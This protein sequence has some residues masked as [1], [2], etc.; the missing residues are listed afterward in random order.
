M[1]RAGLK[2]MIFSI[3]VTPLIQLPK[4]KSLKRMMIA[5][6]T[7][8]CS[9]RKKD[10]NGHFLLHRVPNPIKILCHYLVTVLKVF[11]QSETQ[12]SF[13]TFG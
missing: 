9:L 8:D 13:I 3:K 2:L 10:V 12:F 6:S 4:P 1:P 11:L 5:M 7:M